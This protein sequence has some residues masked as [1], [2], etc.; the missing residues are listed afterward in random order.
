MN[1][2]QRQ[3]SGAPRVLHVVASDVSVGFVRGQ[4]RFLRSLGFDVGGF[5]EIEDI[6]QLPILEK[7]SVRENP[8][9]FISSKA[10][11]IHEPYTTVGT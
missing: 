1:Q 9:L 2:R 5:R 8:L 3:H 4:L 7:A 11:V 10:R 6:K